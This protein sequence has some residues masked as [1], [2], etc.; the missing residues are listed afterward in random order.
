M[1]LASP[2]WFDDDPELAWGFYGHRLELYRRTVPHRGFGVLLSLARRAGRF[3]VFTSNVDGQFQRAG[4]PDDSIVE[5]HG[6][7]HHLQCLDDCDLGLF[8]AEAAVDVDPA[9][10]RARPPLLRCPRCG[11]LARPNVLMFGDFGWDGTRTR[12][13]TLRFKAFEETAP[14]GTCVI[15]CGAGSAIPTVRHTSE[16][17]AARFGGTLVRINVREPNTPPGHVGIPM[18]ALDALTRIDSL[19]GVDCASRRR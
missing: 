3:F 12:D 17:A 5:C 8:P 15:E 14:R 1:D 6:S 19:I 13:Q 7:I 16:R 9:T 11:T 2:G 10:F 18:G 4:F